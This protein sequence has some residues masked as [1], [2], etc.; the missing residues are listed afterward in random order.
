M[1]Y[2][3]LKG[4]SGKTRDYHQFPSPGSDNA[5]SE[6]DST[7]AGEGKWDKVTLRGDACKINQLIYYE[8]EIFQNLI[9]I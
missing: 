3:N 1:P 9:M 7:G 8:R 5:W 4:F 2:V 6:S